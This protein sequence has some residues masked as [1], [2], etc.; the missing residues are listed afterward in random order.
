MENDKIVFGMQS[1]YSINNPEGAMIIV[2]GIKLGTN[3]SILETIP[4][5]DIA[6]ISVSTKIIDIQK[7]SA[8]NPV[9]II[10]ITMKKSKEFLNIKDP[11]SKTNTLFWGPD[12]ITDGFGKVFLSFSCNQIKDVLITVN[13][14]SAEGL[15]GSSSINF[16]AR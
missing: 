9:G 12:L 6:N 16:Q 14:I 15:P 10:E 7:Y 3:A 5:P 1:I 13:G 11:P 8:M 4:V 2:D